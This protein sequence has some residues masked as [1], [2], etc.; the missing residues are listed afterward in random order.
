[1]GSNRIIPATLAPFVLWL[2]AR[3]LIVS[4]VTGKANSINL[5]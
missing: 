1:M 3:Y 4:K 5:G 2:R